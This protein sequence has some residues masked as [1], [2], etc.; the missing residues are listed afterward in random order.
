M[1]GYWDNISGDASDA[2]AKGFVEVLPNGTK[3]QAKIVNCKNESFKFGDGVQ[4][5]WEL[6]DGEFKGQHVFQKLYTHD[7]NEDRANKAR[8]MLKLL[9]TLF[10]I[11]PKDNNAPDNV[12]LGNLVSKCAGLKINEWSME[13]EDGTIGHGNTV[14]EVHPIA[15]FVSV[16]GKYRE[17]TFKTKG[18]SSALTRNPRVGLEAQLDDDIPF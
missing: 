3:A 18:V 11:K 14:A 5:E 6:L 4:I 12:L 10:Q 15:E 2:F 13:Y 8:N 16:I 7:A 9:F 1:T 17:F